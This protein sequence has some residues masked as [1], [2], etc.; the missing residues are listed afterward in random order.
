VL[1]GTPTAS[2]SASG[3]WPMPKLEQTAGGSYKIRQVPAPP[4]AGEA[5]GGPRQ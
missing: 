5:D 2:L 1:E 4:P 3:V